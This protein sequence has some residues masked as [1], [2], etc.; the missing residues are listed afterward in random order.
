MAGLYPTNVNLE[1]S[2]AQ[3]PFYSCNMQ[4]SSC[5]AQL[6]ELHALSKAT[7]LYCAGSLLTQEAAP[8]R[9]LSNLFW[10]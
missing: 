7:G 5:R 4:N 9:H 1:E 2:L 8:Q 6:L 3:D 10:T